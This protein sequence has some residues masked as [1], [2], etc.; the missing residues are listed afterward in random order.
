LERCKTCGREFTAVRTMTYSE[1]G[2]CSWDCLMNKKNRYNNRSQNSNQ[3]QAQ[4]N[5]RTNRRSNGQRNEAAP[6][7]KWAQNY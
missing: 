3:G 7:S 4:H 6:R 5:N 1:Y 2:Y